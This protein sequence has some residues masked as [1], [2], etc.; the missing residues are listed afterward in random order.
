[1]LSAHAI[2][3]LLLDDEL[4]PEPPAGP[5]APLDIDDP[6]TALDRYLTTPFKARGSPVTLYQNWKEKLGGRARKRIND[7]VGRKTYLLDLNDRIAL[8]VWDTDVVSVTP[9][10]GSASTLTAGSPG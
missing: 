6:T 1:M 4:P 9:K 8:R 3:K 5:A 2:Y 7:R 10:T